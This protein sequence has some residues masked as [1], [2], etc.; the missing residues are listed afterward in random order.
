MS[1]RLELPD[2][3]LIAEAVLGVS[4][5]RLQRMILVGLADSA[6]AAPF[7][8]FGGVDFYPEPVERAA[9]CCSRIIRNH[10]F[11]DGNKRV[12]YECM[13]EMLERD[14]I[15]W[16]RPSEDVDEIAGTIEKLAARE[17]SERE[18]VRWTKARTA[19]GD[20]D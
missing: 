2:L 18:F 5:E 15:P 17:V 10:P 6:L 9:I 19:L 12:G 20:G 14:G 4:A 11:P 1:E 7:A 13:R 8:S 16:P 3:L